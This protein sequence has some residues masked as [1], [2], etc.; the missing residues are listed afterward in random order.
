M[1]TQGASVYGDLFPARTSARARRCTIPRTWMSSSIFGYESE[2]V[3]WAQPV[4]MPPFRH[5][6]PGPR[7]RELKL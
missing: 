7:P 2:R 4:A 5:F 6:Y 1:A 3:G